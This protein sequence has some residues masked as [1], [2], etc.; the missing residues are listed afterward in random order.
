MMRLF[1]SCC[2]GSLVV[3]CFIL[4]ACNFGNV[5]DTNG[6]SS[7][8]I[9]NTKNAVVGKINVESEPRGFFASI[10][11]GS[12]V[13]DYDPIHKCDNYGGVNSLIQKIPSSIPKNSL[14]SMSISINCKNGSQFDISRDVQWKS[15]DSNI[16]T[17]S[18][19][20]LLSSHKKGT[21]AVSYIVNGLETKVFVDVTDPSLAGITI[22]TDN[23]VISLGEKAK[24]SV[25]ATYA[26]GSSEQLPHYEVSWSSLDHGI[27]T[28]D[29]FGFIH[30]VNPGI[31]TIKAQHSN[32]STTIQMEVTPAKITSIVIESTSL[33][34]NSIISNEKQI[35]AYAKYNDLSVKEINPDELTCQSYSNS[36]IDFNHNCIAVLKSSGLQG[37]TKIKVSYAGFESMGIFSVV[38]TGVEALRIETNDSQ[39]VMNG[40]HVH[41]KIYAKIGNAFYDETAHIKLTSSNANV[42]FVDVSGV[43]Q[44]DG[45]GNTKLTAL[46]KNS[47]SS[48]L[49]SSFTLYVDDIVISPSSENILHVGNTYNPVVT[50]KNAK[51]NKIT[52][53]IQPV[54][55]LSNNTDVIDINEENSFVAKAP[56]VSL[57]RVEI[58][59]GAFINEMYRVTGIS[60]LNTESSAFVGEEIAIGAHMINEDGTTTDIT[61]TA[62]YFL[63]SSSET[64]RFYNGK[65][66]ISKPG[67]YSIMVSTSNGFESAYDV[68]VYNKPV[69]MLAES[70]AGIYLYNTDTHLVSLRNSISTINS[71]TYSN[72]SY[73]G[74]GNSGL[75]LTSKDYGKTW[76]QV[77]SGVTS[78]N[79]EKVVSGQNGIIFAV[80]Q[81]GILVRTSDGV[82]WVK[83]TLLNKLNEDSLSVDKLNNFMVSNYDGSKLYSSKGSGEWSIKSIDKAFYYY[84][85]NTTNSNSYIAAGYAGQIIKSSDLGNSWKDVTVRELCKL[86]NGYSN[87]HTMIQNEKGTIAMA[88]NCG[89]LFTSSNDGNNWTRQHISSTNNFRSLALTNT[90]DFLLV[91]SNGTVMKST[92]GIVW[93]NIANKYSTVNFKEAISPNEPP[94][95]LRDVAYIANSNSSGLKV[96]ICDIENKSLSNCQDAGFNVSNV[97]P[98]SIE[99][100]RDKRFAYI[101]TGTSGNGITSTGIYR[102]NINGVD[103]KFYGCVQVVNNNVNTR[104]I[105]ITEDGARFYYSNMYKGS[106]ERC[107]INQNDGALNNCNAIVNVSS[108]DRMMITPD[109][110]YAYIGGAS[111]LTCDLSKRSCS[112]INNYSTNYGG[113]MY[114]KYN[115]YYYFML[116]T[117]LLVKNISNDGFFSNYSTLYGNYVRHD[118]DMDFYDASTAYISK[119]GAVYECKVDDSISSTTYGMIGDCSLNSNVKSKM[120]ENILVTK[121]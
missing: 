55:F 42:A 60:L 121:I 97:R 96:E 94:K 50:Y 33:V 120:A 22:S 79:L 58:P 45:Y 102:C 91:G 115:G 77:G 105:Y 76:S 110:K 12:D 98:Y 13:E 99:V 82:K 65:T 46:F 101:G 89:T 92:D 6:L 73:F 14:Y 112:G 34:M 18:E 62:N 30:P 10:L 38:R 85:L 75:I 113:M 23:P 49:E 80:A 72:N 32:R 35:N 68:V 69:M 29:L 41:Y 40:E 5:N 109:E 61:N 8:P 24:L 74:V 78:S 111:L 52:S 31:V 117:P 114:N 104:S 51:T 4:S 19:S 21:T 59:G 54:E 25:V 84:T 36:V 70:G 20:G 86:G 95:Y 47:D 90:G 27:A 2:L 66:I 108:I 44:A 16:F 39:K 88:G 48:V 9:L 119:I 63:K 100:S 11:S 93:A 87:M 26:D 106:L 53:N 43:I 7:V 116:R 107:D 64:I 15:Y 67:N 57:M 56:G 28:V 17:V 103:L 83:E 3:F 118:V 71:I 1:K 37:D 81:S